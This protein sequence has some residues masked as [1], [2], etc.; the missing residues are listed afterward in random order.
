MPK[1]ILLFI[2]LI[3]F[4]FSESNFRLLYSFNY[5]QPIVNKELSDYIEIRGLTN[6]SIGLGFDVSI[7]RARFTLAENSYEGTIISDSYYIAETQTILSNKFLDSH[8]FL[9]SALSLPIQIPLS[10]LNSS[11]AGSWDIAIGYKFIVPLQSYRNINSYKYKLTTSCYAN[12][13]IQST[14][15]NNHGIVLSST[16]SSPWKISIGFEYFFG[17]RNIESVISKSTNRS[18]DR[19]F[20]IDF[21]DDGSYLVPRD[22]SLILTYQ[23]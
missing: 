12:D 23:F 10:F 3:Q 7:L 6:H 9:E 17:L 15:N 8:I 21:Q 18:D 1:Y 5:T 16:Y 11:N 2:I 20:G 19:I 13:C 22:L 4:S 14:I